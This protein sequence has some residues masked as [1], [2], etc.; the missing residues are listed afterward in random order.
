MTQQGRW[1][2]E[3]TTFSPI[4]DRDVQVDVDVTVIANELGDVLAVTRF[5]TE[6]VKARLDET[7]PYVSD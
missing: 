6:F 5:V 4:Y 3:R 7:L 1:F 2:I